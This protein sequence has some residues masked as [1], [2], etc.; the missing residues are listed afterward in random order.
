MAG[1]DLSSPGSCL[2]QFQPMPFIEC[3]GP[4]GSCFFYSNSKS[5]WMTTVNATDQ[6]SPPTPTILNF[7]DNP[8]TRVSR[9]SV[10]LRR[11]TT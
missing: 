2:Q 4:A 8:Q 7:S 6:F 9:C 3:N 1:Q 10:C 11:F 5:F